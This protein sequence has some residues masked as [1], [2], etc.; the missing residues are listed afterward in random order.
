MELVETRLDQAGK[1]N[2]AGEEEAGRKR[3]LREQQRKL[4]SLITQKI[5]F[6]R[7]GRLRHRK[8]RAKS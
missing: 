4:K 8:G 3:R 2:R 5:E 7:A 6:G 1:R